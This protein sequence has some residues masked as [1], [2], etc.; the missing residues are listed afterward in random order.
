[1]S[2]HIERVL[3]R[4]L[5]GM[6]LNNYK[7]VG[8]VRAIRKCERLS[9]QLDRTRDH[10][11]KMYASDLKSANHEVEFRQ[12]IYAGQLIRI[13]NDKNRAI[14]ENENP[15]L[16]LK[17]A[18]SRQKIV[19]RNGLKRVIEH[20]SEQQ[21]KE[22]HKTDLETDEQHALRREQIR[23]VQLQRSNTTTQE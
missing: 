22:G 5:R 9:Q 7:T 1:M 8:D 17:N 11:D 6:T 2:D 14:K 3:Q 21:G 15:N 19:S 13:Q 20:I 16:I 23:K 10:M 12:K 4:N 18:G